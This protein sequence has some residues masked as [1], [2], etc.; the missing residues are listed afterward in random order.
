[1][2]MVWGYELFREIPFRDTELHFLYLSIMSVDSRDM[3]RIC[4]FRQVATKQ[5]LWQ[6]QFIILGCFSVY[7]G[8]PS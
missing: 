7:F 5:F 8:L 2:R 4:C 6:L 3:Q 1:M